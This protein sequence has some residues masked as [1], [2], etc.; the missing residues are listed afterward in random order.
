MLKH[1]RVTVVFSI[2]LYFYLNI[3]NTVCDPHLTYLYFYFFLLLQLHYC[4]NLLCLLP[5]AD[6]ALAPSAGKEDRLRSGQVRPLQEHLCCS[7][8]LP[9][10]HCAAGR[11]WRAALWVLPFHSFFRTCLHRSCRSDARCSFCLS[12]YAFPYIIL[13]LSLVTLAVYMSASEIQV[14]THNAAPTADK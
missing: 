2:T 14:K 9:H 10:P 8:L 6:D 12:D 1:I 11:G 7:V 4:V 13:V 3:Y 5:G